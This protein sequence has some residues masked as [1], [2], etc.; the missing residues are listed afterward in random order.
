MDWFL[1]GPWKAMRYPSAAKVL[2]SP[3]EETYHEVFNIHFAIPSYAIGISW[4]WR[5]RRPLVTQSGTAGTGQYA[6]S[7]LDSLEVFAIQVSQT[8]P[9]L[10]VCMQ[11]TQH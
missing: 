6:A 8:R 7:L 9:L 5:S 1:K 3:K 10:C 2:A 4:L 11:H